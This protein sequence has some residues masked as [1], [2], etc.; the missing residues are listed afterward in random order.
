M[1]EQKSRILYPVRYP[2]YLRGFLKEFDNIKKH[3]I[4]SDSNQSHIFLYGSER[5]DFN[6]NLCI[7]LAEI[8]EDYIMAQLIRN[9]I[10]D[11]GIE[12]KNEE[13]LMNL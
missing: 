5:I 2:N 8:S 9:N 11:F 12:H 7:G 13:K 1:Q 6:I 3:G 10:F 4:R